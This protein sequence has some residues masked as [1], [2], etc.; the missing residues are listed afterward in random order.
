MIVIARNY[1]QLGNRLVLASNLI[2]AAREYNVGLVN[3]SFVD[4]APYFS[5]T[6]NDLWCR[7][8]RHLNETQRED[9]KD[10]TRSPA[11]WRR[12]S[13]YKSVYLFGRTLSHL[14]LHRFP[15]NVV[16][17]G[18]EGYCDVTSDSFRAKARSTRPLFCS[19]WLFDAKDLLIKHAD[20]IR[21]Y[22]QILPAHQDNVNRLVSGIRKNS[23]IIVG[24]HIRHGD[25]ATFRGG[26]YYYPIHQYV[27]AMR[28]IRRQFE[29]Q[30]ISF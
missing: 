23:E 9:S 18:H 3:P 8:T 25:Y 29:G 2:A 16:R 19:G 5:S 26:R 22:F 28:R 1:G 17:L 24:V 12:K 4:Y 6:C 27:A 13:L 11:L 10:A 15:C 30:S 14:R 7:Y 21:D 20:A